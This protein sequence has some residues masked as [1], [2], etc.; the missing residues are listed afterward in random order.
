MNPNRKTSS[1]VALGV[2]APGAISRVSIGD[3]LR[4]AAQRD[5]DKTVLVDGEVRLSYG[6]LD[7][8]V[9][10]CANAL[11]A[12]GLLPGERV[13]TLCN[14]SLD[15]VVAFFGI[16]RAGLIWVPINT[17]LGLDDVRYI[18]EHAEARY[19]IV[20]SAQLL[21]PELRMLLETQPGCGL[22]IEGPAAGALRAFN[23]ALDAQPA[24]EPDVEIHDRDVSQIMYTSGT[25]GRPKGVMQTHQA[26]VMAAL[27]NAMEMGLRREDIGNA[28]MPLFHCAQHTF[29]FTFMVVGATAILHRGFD[30]DRLLT[31][32]EREHMTFIFALPLMYQAMLDHPSRP[33]RDLSSLRLCFYAMAPMAENLLRR[34]ISE[35]CPNFTLGSGQTEMYPMTVMFRP[36]E[37]LRRFGPYWGVTSILNDTA[38]M[39]DAGRIL[40][41]GEIGEIVHRGPNVM[42]GYYKNPEATAEA[43]TFGWHHTGDL[44]MWDDGLLMFKDRKKDMIK[45]GGE[46]VP[47]IKVESALLRHAAVGNAVVV[48]L[49]HPR[50]IEAITAFVVL[51]PGTKTDE[52]E[53]IRHCKEHLGGFE[54][55]KAIRILT[56]LPM[57]A[58][59]KV[60]KHPLRDQYRDLY[61]AS[62]TDSA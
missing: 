49:P 39:D 54:V 60:Q 9:S 27:A 23:A 55:P 6:Q 8:R 2:P 1:L 59:G 52:A 13:V 21:R 10:R 56:A 57:T 3:F 12:D 45:T 25:T 28:M 16:Q 30:A 15:F 43:R 61:T 5:P 11:I 42:E 18:V 58:T 34:L 7:A 4:R 20:D 50:W 29:L 31:D 40:G 51:K 38:I 32:I 48:G 19:A 53:L 24:N 36:E 14:N 33:S 46:N 47:S 22:V 62:S 44:G 41:P 35:F 17:S 37:Q 26:V